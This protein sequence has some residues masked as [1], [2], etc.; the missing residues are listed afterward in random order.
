[1]SDYRNPIMNETDL[2][3]YENFLNDISKSEKADNKNGVFEKLI[4]KRINI[5]VSCDKCIHSYFGI[6]KKVEKEYLELCQKD[7]KRI[8]ILNPESVISITIL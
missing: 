4:G 7:G 8:L 5:K 3:S 6:L 2:L 1:M